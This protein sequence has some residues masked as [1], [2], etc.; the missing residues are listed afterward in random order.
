MDKNQSDLNYSIL[1]RLKDWRER[2]KEFCFEL[3][4]LR[5]KIGEVKNGRARKE[6]RK[7]GGRMIVRENGREGAKIIMLRKRSRDKKKYREKEVKKERDKEREKERWDSKRDFMRVI[8]RCRRC[9]WERWRDMCW[10]KIR[11]TGGRNWQSLGWTSATVS[12]SLFLFL[13]LS[14]SLNVCACVCV[15]S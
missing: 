5:L 12:L 14:L 10:K 11:K 2:W 3:E 7:K 6:G 4:C 8:E 1:L 9:C 13:S 15:C